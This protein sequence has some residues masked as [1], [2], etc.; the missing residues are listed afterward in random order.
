M[1]RISQPENQWVLTN[2]QLP[3]EAVW[4]AVWGVIRRLSQS[5]GGSSQAL[6]PM[7]QWEVGSSEP[8]ASHPPF[9]PQAVRSAIKNNFFFW[10][11]NSCS[12]QETWKAKKSIEG[13]KNPLLPGITPINNL[14]FLVLRK[15]KVIN[16]VVCVQ[17]SLRLML[18]YFFS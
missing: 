3:E 8:R 12:L 4:G 2:H 13:K 14:Y 1:T 15:N 7:H 11:Y 18:F 5:P 6:R 10:S 9:T 17:F 16:S